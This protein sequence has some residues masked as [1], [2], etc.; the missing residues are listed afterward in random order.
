MISGPIALLITVIILILLEGFFSG[1]EIA[2]V[3]A[4][5]T[6]LRKRYGA[7]SRVAIML[8]RFLK[9]PQ[10]LIGTH[11]IGTNLCVVAASTLATFYF[12]E[13]YGALGE[14]Y[15]L[16]IMSPTLLLLGEM[17]PKIAYQE[18]ADR[19]ASKS[20]LGLYFF[21]YVFYPLVWFLALLGE[22]ASRILGGEKGEAEPF[23]PRAE[24]KYLLTSYQR[25]KDLPL[26]E[27]RMIRR[28][29]RFSETTIGEVMIPLVEIRA[30][31]EMDTI[32]RALT[33]ANRHPYSR[34]PVYRKRI[35]N[36]TGLLKM[37]DLLAGSDPLK[38]I[39]E[40]AQPV[41]FVPET[42]PV[43]QLLARMQRENFQTAVVA[44][45]YGGC[46]GVITREDILEEIIGEIEDEHTQ[47]KPLYRQLSENRWLINARMEIDQINESLGLNLPKEDY[48]TLAGFL[49]NQFQRIPRSGELIRYR[50]LIFLVKRASP[51][52]ILEV[53]VSK[54]PED[55]QP[56][57]S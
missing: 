18:Y 54:E 53:M 5:K 47:E 56:S 21:S 27:Q 34:Y 28:I 9:E 16:L 23:L 37:T 1:S 24:L 41:N 30:L 19:L 7:Q 31:E 55:H 13:K 33:L 11:L 3:S 8:E 36:I 44:D 46:I 32:E 26:H 17:V 20:L 29:F 43:D 45:E 25:R 6:L 40:L 57:E 39:G 14:L 38:K 4:N 10:W 50:D 51:R 12:R 49:L 15:T 42:M 48:E 22:G 52:A 2:I 35:D